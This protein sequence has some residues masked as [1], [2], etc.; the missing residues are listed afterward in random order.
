VPFL[1]A[2]P[3]IVD[4]P[5]RRGRQAALQTLTVDEEVASVVADIETGAPEGP[6]TLVAHSSGGLVVPGMVPLSTAA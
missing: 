4:L 6:V 5:G 3:L 1:E 2:P